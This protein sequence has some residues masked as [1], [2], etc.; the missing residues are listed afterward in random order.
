MTRLSGAKSLQFL[1]WLLIV[2]CL[3][4]SSSAGVARAQAGRL[5][6]ILVGDTVSEE[7]ADDMTA[8]L[9]RLQQLLRNNVPAEQLAVVV[10]DGR[11]FS[12]TR[13][14]RAIRDATVTPDDALLFFYC[15]HGYYEAP[16]GSFFLPP[17]DN[18][19]R[20]QFSD[21]RKALEAR[22]PRL[23]V[24]LLDCCSII[25]KGSMARFYQAPANL[26]QVPLSPLF[27]TLF[28]ESAGE[29]IINSSKP[30][31]YAICRAHFAARENG[32]TYTQGSLFAGILFDEWERNEEGRNWEE[33]F[34]TLRT[35]VD[36]DFRKFYPGRVIT[37]GSGKQVPQTTQTVWG[38][39]NGEIFQ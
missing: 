9:E 12:R 4:W 33:L 37:L 34:E 26:E 14:L 15:G 23:R 6:A 29:I 19:A 13:V 22:K 11:D 28:F 17:A 21:I 20:F 5:V 16:G 35:R 25:P 1:L 31:E 39:E 32:N 24:A 36:R 7:I 18:G 30:G 38:F 10:L 27:R 8:N 2:V 3:A